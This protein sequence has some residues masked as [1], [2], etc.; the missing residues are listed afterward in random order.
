[1]SYISFM[2]MPLIFDIPVLVNYALAKNVTHKSY[3]P[4]IKILRNFFTSTV[5]VFNFLEIKPTRVVHILVPCFLILMQ[6]VKAYIYL[7]S[8]L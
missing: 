4:Y 1:M 5:V 6:T 2:C 3:T 7:L 8:Y